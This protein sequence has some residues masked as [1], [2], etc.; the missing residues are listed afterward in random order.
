[1]TSAEY[2]KKIRNK[3]TRLEAAA[4]LAPDQRRQKEKLKRELYYLNKLKKCRN[5]AEKE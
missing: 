2:E 5:S 4:E 3:L 1:M